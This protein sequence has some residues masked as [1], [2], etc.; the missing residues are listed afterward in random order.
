MCSLSQADKAHV[1]VILRCLSTCLSFHVFV[2]S[3]CT[4]SYLCSGSYLQLQMSRITNICNEL[5]FVAGLV[6]G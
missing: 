5:D 6:S 4:F 1:I 3:S 2:V